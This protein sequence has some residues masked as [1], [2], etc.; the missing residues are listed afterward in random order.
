MLETPF[1]LLIALLELLAG[2]LTAL[3]NL[4]TGAAAGAGAALGL[5]EALVLLAVVLIELLLWLVLTLFEWVRAL[6]SRRR[7]R[8]VPR[9]RLWRPRPR[10][11]Q[12]LKGK[13]DAAGD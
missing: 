8:A 1:S 10:P 7:P 11:A 6:L 9:P 4:L 3:I 2:A 5:G 13:Q 12:V